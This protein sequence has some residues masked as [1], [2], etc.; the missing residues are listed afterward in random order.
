MRP[1]LRHLDFWRPLR[2]GPVRVSYGILSPASITG[3]LRFFLAVF[4][5]SKAAKAAKRVG[6]ARVGLQGHESAARRRPPS[7]PQC[8]ARARGAMR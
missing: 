3:G 1:P 5:R 4:K 8:Y 2:I 6:G 7:P